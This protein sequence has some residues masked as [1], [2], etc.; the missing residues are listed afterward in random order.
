MEVR[1]TL[2]INFTIRVHCVRTNFKHFMWLSSATQ[3]VSLGFRSAFSN[4]PTVSLLLFLI[5][6]LLS[7]IHKLASSSFAFSQSSFSY[8]KKVHK[9]AQVCKP[10]TYLCSHTQ[11]HTVSH[12]HF[13]IRK[14]H[15]CFIEFDLEPGHEIRRQ[16]AQVLSIFKK[17][18]SCTNSPV[19]QLAD[20]RERTEIRDSR[21]WGVKGTIIK[22]VCMDAFTSAR[23]LCVCTMPALGVV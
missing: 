13:H 11:T 18:L 1:C 2:N 9:W 7:W 10:H 19:P 23:V 22:Y 8:V 16:I 6:L 20:G 17:N 3:F 5:F 12:T 21:R 15:S 4:P 14:E